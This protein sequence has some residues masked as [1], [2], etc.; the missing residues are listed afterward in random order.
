M[1]RKLVKGRQRDVRL[2][3][4]NNSKS[5]FGVIRCSLFIVYVSLWGKYHSF[6]LGQYLEGQRESAE[7]ITNTL[8]KSGGRFIGSTKTD[9][10]ID[11]WT[12]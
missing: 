10:V 5:Q 6:C 3:S 8:L 1:G 9:Q 4:I 12:D 11:R 7:R 2:R